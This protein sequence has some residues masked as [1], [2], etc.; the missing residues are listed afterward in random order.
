MLF[1]ISYDIVF[2]PSN[3]ASK[4]G[5]SVLHMFE[6][7]SQRNNWILQSSIDWFNWKSLQKA[8]LKKK[9]TAAHFFTVAFLKINLHDRLRKKFIK[10]KN[11]FLFGYKFIL[12]YTS[13]VGVKKNCRNSTIVKELFH[14]KISKTIELRACLK[15]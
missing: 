13:I 12:M 5:Y 2:F 1:L 7:L 9:T 15:I 4:K 10:L 6:I 11:R 14:L 3:K 8:T